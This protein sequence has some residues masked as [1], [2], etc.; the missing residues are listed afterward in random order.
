[1]VWIPITASKGRVK[2][3]PP[4]SADVKKI[5]AGA[6]FLLILTEDCE[7]YQCDFKPENEGNLEAY[8]VKNLKGKAIKEIAAGSM[9]RIALEREDIKPADEWSVE[10]TVEW[11]S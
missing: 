8:F 1:M 4:K 9:H 7:V 5:C 6:N 3:L 10:E 11:L 2:G